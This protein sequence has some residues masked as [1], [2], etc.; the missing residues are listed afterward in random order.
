[1]VLVTEAFD[2]AS[3]MAVYGTPHHLL[4]SHRRGL[5]RGS[6]GRQDVYLVVGQRQRPDERERQDV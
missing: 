6:L 5:E 2:S 3:M 4:Q 1:M